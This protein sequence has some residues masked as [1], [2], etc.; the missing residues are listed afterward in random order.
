MVAYIVK[1]I[2]SCAI[3]Y[4]RKVKRKPV[5]ED[6]EDHT[7]L[8]LSLIHIWY[9]AG[10]GDLHIGRGEGKFVVISVCLNQHPGE[11]ADFCRDGRR[12]C[13]PLGGGKQ[14]FSITGK[15]HYEYISFKRFCQRG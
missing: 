3:D 6:I 11:D 14:L 7:E 4:C 2:Q 13:R 15:L 12:L 1:A 9:G 10:N 5:F 8:T